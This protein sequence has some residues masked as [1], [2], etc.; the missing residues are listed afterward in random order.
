MTFSPQV[1]QREQLCRADP[2]AL[3]AFF[4]DR[5]NLEAI[6]PGWLGFSIT[7]PG[8]IEM[9]QNAR[10]EYRLHLAGVPIRWRTRILAWDP[11]SHFIGAQEA[12]PF[13]LWEHEHHF[14][15]LTGGVYRL[16]RVRYQ[17]PHG[18]AGCRLAGLPVRAALNAIFDPRCGVIVDI[19]GGGTNV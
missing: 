14:E 12:G 1:L 10:I 16:D 17:L 6:T 19:F 18:S 2:D 11:G 5:R 8:A 13:A 4:A 7:T 3:F 9:Q 15:V